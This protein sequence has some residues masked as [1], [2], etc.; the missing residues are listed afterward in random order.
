MK[1][2]EN[3]METTLKRLET[4][5]MTMYFYIGFHLMLTMASVS[6]HELGTLGTTMSVEW[7]LGPGFF[8]YLPP[9]WA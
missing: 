6:L 8:M 2:Y 3:M 5:D 9:L 7:I 1:T 4:E